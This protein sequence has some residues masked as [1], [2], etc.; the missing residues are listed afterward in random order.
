[1]SYTFLLEQGEESLA[2]CFSDIPV[3]VLSKLNLIAEKSCCNGNEMESCPSFLSGMMCEHSTENRGGEQLTLFAEDFPVRTLAVLENEQESQAPSL[4]YGQIWREWFAKLDQGSFSWK[5]RE[6]WLFEDLEPFCE[7][8]PEWGMMLDG[9]CFQLVRLV[10]HT[11]DDECSCLPTPRAEDDHG[12]GLIGR[13]NHRNLRDWL[14]EKELARYPR[15]R[16]AEFW[17]WLMG[18]P[19][20]ASALNPLETAKFQQWLNSHGKPCPK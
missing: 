5:M 12:G 8:W 2:E 19:I 3:S 13:D 4:V 16:N 9:E 20:G 14:R 7:T 1:M 10:C 6:T 17:E 15:Q 11:C 18:W